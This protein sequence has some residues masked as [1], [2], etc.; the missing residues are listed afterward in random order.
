[1]KGRGREKEEKDIPG[2][3]GAVS[4][5]AANISPAGKTVRGTEK[6]LNGP[7]E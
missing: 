3:V 2:R 7:F 5:V 1:M 6:P 4:N